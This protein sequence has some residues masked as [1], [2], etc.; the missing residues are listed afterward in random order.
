MRGGAFFQ[1]GH[2]ATR[3]K[4]AQ[5]LTAALAASPAAD[6]FYQRAVMT[7]A[8][9]ACRLFA[10]DVATALAASEAQARG[11]AL[12]S[13]VDP[14]SLAAGEAQASAAGAA[15]CRSATIATAAEHVR[16]AFASYAHLDH[17]D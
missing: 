4:Q 1:A 16:A 15:D 2:M 17:M 5:A 13:G 12:R 10:P 8:G 11:A 7:A 3:G 9:G 14:A 6:L